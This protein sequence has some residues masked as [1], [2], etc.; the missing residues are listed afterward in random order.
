MDVAIVLLVFGILLILIEF[1]I[2]PGT[3]VAGMAGFVSAAVGIFYAYYFIG[4]QSGTILLFSGGLVGYGVFYFLSKSS[5]GGLL[6]MNA[7]VKE[8]IDRTTDKIKKGDIGRTMG[9]LMPYGNAIINNEIFEV[10]ALEETI[11]ENREIIVIKVQKNRI[12]VKLNS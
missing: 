1:F 3:T 5:I 11:Q 6:K 12:F 4:W 8:K 7:S 2:I 9:R 10:K